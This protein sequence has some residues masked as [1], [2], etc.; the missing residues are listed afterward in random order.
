MVSGGAVLGDRAP[1]FS[2]TY[3]HNLPHLAKLNLFLFV[4]FRIFMSSDCGLVYFS[5]L[6][7]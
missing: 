2:F 7:I 5:L 4:V 1:R 3:Q 6:S